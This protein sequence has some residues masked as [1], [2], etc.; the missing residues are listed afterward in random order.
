MRQAQKKADKRQRR[1]SS[2]SKRKRRQMLPWRD[3]TRIWNKRK[4][5][6]LFKAT[7]S[8]SSDEQ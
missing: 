8:T 3:P 7:D 5:K 1:E 4:N 2:L 6:L